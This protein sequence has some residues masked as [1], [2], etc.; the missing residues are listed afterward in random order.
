MKVVVPK[1]RCPHCKA[2]WIPRV[3]MPL[4]CPRCG[5]KLKED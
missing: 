1:L 4:R 3:T 2:E 5:N